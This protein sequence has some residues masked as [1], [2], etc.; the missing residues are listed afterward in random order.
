MLKRLIEQ[1]IAPLVG[2][3]RK[4]VPAPVLAS[5]ILVFNHIP[6]TAGTSFNTLISNNV[7]KNTIL[8][9]TFGQYKHLQNLTDKEKEALYAITGH[10]PFS[11]FN[12]IRFPK[13][14]V[15]MTFLRDPVER[16]ISFYGYIHQNVTHKLHRRVV[17]E[18]MTLAD[19]IA[20]VETTE[21]DNLQ[22][23]FLCS[24]D[25]S[26]VPI[27]GCTESLLEEAKNNLLNSFPLLGM[28]ESFESAAIR[29]G[30][31]LGWS[32]LA[33]A[34]E[35]L[36]TKK[37]RQQEIDEQTLTIINDRNQLDWKLYEF[38]KDLLAERTSKST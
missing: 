17:K 14:L 7:P 15:H 3:R 9:L 8:K 18:K 34:K 11:Y 13:P 19:F 38:A 5:Q 20:K 16:I 27:G 28:Q 10:L 26:S 6:K 35:N 22:V 4:L 31:H 21:L 32:N 37:L 12:G 23:R 24:T 2:H 36:T 29:C 33:V 25:Y 1:R 30:E